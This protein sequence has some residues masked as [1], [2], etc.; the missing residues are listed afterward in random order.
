MSKNRITL[1]DYLNSQ[2]MGEAVSFNICKSHLEGTY[3]THKDPITA[4]IINAFDNAEYGTN[5]DSFKSEIG[6]AIAQLNKVYEMI[7]E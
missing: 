2:D 7:K 6:Y 5:T 1:E 4:V 3:K